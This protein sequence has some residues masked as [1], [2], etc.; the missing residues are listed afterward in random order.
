MKILITGGCG[1][2]ASNLANI[3][4]NNEHQVDIIDTADQP[5]HQFAKN[6]LQARYNTDQLTIFEKSIQEC[7]FDKLEQYDL[8]IHAAALT[9]IPQSILEPQQDFNSNVI[10]TQ[11]LL[12]RL[13]HCGKKIPTIIFSSVKPY[14]VDNISFKKEGKRYV[15]TDA[16]LFHDNIWGI[17]E[18]HLL[19]PDEPY[20]GNKAAQSL[21][22]QCYA[23]SYDLPIVIFRFSNLYA[24]MK[25][26]LNHGWLTTFCIR[27][28]LEQEIRIEGGGYQVRDMLHYKDIYNAINLAVKHIDRVK[29]QIFNIGGGEENSVS[30][31]EA[32][33]LLEKIS[34]RKV[35]TIQAEGRK[36]EDPI[37]ITNY[38][39]FSK[40]TG[41]EPKVSV[42]EGMTQIYNWAVEN[43]ELIKEL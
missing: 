30:I 10:A 41:W 7:S 18:N 38:T 26:R 28:A 36:F 15:W 2:V 16:N 19:A 21:I 42:K 9:N 23:I 3:Y 6:L 25:T 29:K 27:H 34:D 5:R 32:I 35:K 17:R 1:V 20:A 11:Y 43:K 14:K 4:L 22:S 12:E 40:I 39:K 13:R 31:L 24:P 37:F 8:I 33:D